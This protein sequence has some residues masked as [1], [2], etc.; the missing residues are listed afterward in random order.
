MAEVEDSQWKE[1]RG[2]RPEDDSKAKQVQRTRVAG[3]GYAGTVGAASVSACVPVCTVRD[4]KRNL[5]NLAAIF[6]FHF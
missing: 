3:G 6:F 5:I 4:K 2:K 1:R